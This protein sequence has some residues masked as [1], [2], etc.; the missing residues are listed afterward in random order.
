MKTLRI[1]SELESKKRGLG[2]APVFWFVLFT[3]LRRCPF[4]I[5]IKEEEDLQ[6]V[7]NDCPN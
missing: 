6:I 7:E 5:E 3:D 4:L 2:I 1:E